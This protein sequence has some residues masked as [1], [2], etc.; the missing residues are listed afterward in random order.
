MAHCNKGCCCVAI[1]RY[2]EYQKFTESDV[3][4]GSLDQDIDMDT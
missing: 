1:S 4:L 2:Q 3:D